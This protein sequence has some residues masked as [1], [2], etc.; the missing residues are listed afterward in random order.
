MIVEQV[1]KDFWRLTVKHQSRQ[2]V[3]F[4]TKGKEEVTAKF[5]RYVQEAASPLWQSIDNLKDFGL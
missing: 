4:S 5:N 3:F 2:L 1:S